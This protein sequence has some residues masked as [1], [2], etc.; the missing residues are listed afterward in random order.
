MRG[1]AIL[2]KLRQ[3]P[4]LPLRRETIYH[5]VFNPAGTA[6]TLLNRLIATDPALA[7]AMLRLAPRPVHALLTV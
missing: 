4:M 2:R 3:L 1:S 5:I 7:L 6:P